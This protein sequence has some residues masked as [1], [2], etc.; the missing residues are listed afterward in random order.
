[1]RSCRD[2]ERN[3]YKI[4]EKKQRCNRELGDTRVFINERLGEYAVGNKIR[5]SQRERSRLSIAC[6]YFCKSVI[7]IKTLH[8]DHHLVLGSDYGNAK[9]NAVQQDWVN[10]LKICWSVAASLFKVKVRLEV[11]R[12]LCNIW[13]SQGHCKE[14][15]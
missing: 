3:N 8:W 13:L 4:N 10:D 9:C 7:V 12:R 1:M 5:N 14:L 6:F 15:S 11:E 2:K